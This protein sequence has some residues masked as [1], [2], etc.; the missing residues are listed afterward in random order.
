MAPF[1]ELNHAAGFPDFVTK[2]SINFTKATLPESGSVALFMVTNGKV[3]QLGGGVQLLHL[4][5]VV[6]LEKIM[7]LPTIDTNYFT[8]FLVDLLNIASPTGFAEPAIEFVEKELSKY[9]QLQLSR[10]RKGALVAKW[11]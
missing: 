3:Y 8:T 2:S 11:T 6:Y 9:K 4:Y 5:F 7:T 10:T 1:A